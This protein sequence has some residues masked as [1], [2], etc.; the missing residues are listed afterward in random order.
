M[1]NLSLCTGIFPDKWKRATV[2]PVHMSGDKTKAEN[3]RQVWLLSLPGII[4]EKIV[5]INLTQYL[6]GHEVLSDK[7][8]GFRKNFSSLSGSGPNKT[9]FSEQLIIGRLPWQFC[10]P[11][12]SV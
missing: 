6:E 8:S 2:I 7:Q 1:F 12:Q 4:F 9:P 5:H 10:G 11:Q 3:F